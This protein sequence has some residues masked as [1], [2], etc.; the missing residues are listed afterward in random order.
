MSAYLSNDKLILIVMKKIKD[1]GVQK[2]QFRINALIWR[3]QL[4]TE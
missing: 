2:L 4:L 1:I 3:K